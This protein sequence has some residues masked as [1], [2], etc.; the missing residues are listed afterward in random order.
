MLLENLPYPKD[1]RV[2]NE[3]TSLTAAGWDVTVVA[4]MAQGE[5]RREVVEGVR[6][7]RYPLPSTEPGIKGYLKEYAHAHL[8]LFTRGLAC[9]LRGADVVHIHNPPDTLFPI[10]LAARALGKSVV[11]DSH[12]LSPELFESKFGGSRIVAGL[13][14]AQAASFRVAS[15]AIVTNETHRER[16]LGRGRKRS[17][18]V[19]VVRNGP[20]RATLRLG[21]H[22]SRA[23]V[24]ETPELA[25]VGELADQDGIF[26]LPALLA[27]PALRGARLTMV[28]DG[29][30]RERLE[31][32]FERLGVADRV[33]FTGW[34]PHREV[35]SF[36]AAAD[37]C[38][39]PAPCNPLNHGSTMVKIGEYLA[40]SRPVVA[41]A[42]NET[43][44]TA[45]DA[46]LYADDRD[47]EAFAG[48]VARLAAEPELRSNLSG[49]ARQRA[50]DLVWE[51]SEAALLAAYARLAPAQS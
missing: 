36:I 44:R 30:H 38:I 15:V 8:H 24:L 18:D 3:A 34:V 51:R 43:R 2:R 4:P 12:D 46:A 29:P 48:L 9:L 40:A 39:D 21:G 11:Y 5:A 42:L 33:R 13:R 50:F 1:V 45:R 47:A 6:V 14:A 37:I 22:D 32:E 35:A 31:H 7:W 27:H 26:D 17:E 23:G 28:G 20:R 19:F 10:G 25:F 49:R 16:A 41:Y